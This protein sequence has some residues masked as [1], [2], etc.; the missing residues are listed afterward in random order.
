MTQ[1]TPQSAP[2]DTLPQTDHSVPLNLKPLIIAYMS[3][4]MAM[5]A[6]V[7]LIGPISRSLHLA[8][9]QA[10]A[11]VTVGGVLWM[12]LSRPWGALS[13]KRGR[14][15]VLL[16]GVG[17]FML[18]YWAMCAVLILSLH[19]Q[20]A[21]WV[22]FIGLLITRGAIGGFFAAIPTTSQA[23]IAD[24]IAPARRANVM[25]SLGAANGIGLVA[26][27]AMAAMLA[28]YG[29]DLPLYLTALLPLLALLILWRRLPRTT[30]VNDIKP[31]SLRLG[32]ARLRQAML[33]AFA[34]M[35]SVAVGQIA[36]G[37]FAI[38]RLGLE[39]ESAAQAAGFAL[40]L[41]G[42][43]LITS[44]LIVRKLSWTPHRL[45]R[46][47]GLI[48][49][50]GFAAVA[51]VN[52]QWM[53]MLCYFFAAAG[54]GWIFP[55][56]SALAANAV[57]PHEQGAAAGSIGA[58]QGLGIVLG[59]LAGSLLYEVSPGVPYVLVGILLVLVALFAATG[60]TKNKA[61]A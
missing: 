17:G 43:G 53:L 5:M 50:A 13:D 37:F 52:S 28:K 41:V 40:T 18:A 30:V 11:V 58:A 39:P 42:V 56:F 35:F 16:I 36:V 24:H 3:C 48:S 23:L 7:S 8:P 26:G 49:A 19:L 31:A 12:L 22:V 47:G 27:P 54:M 34:A 59:P 60:P 15:P 1:D 57:E 61:T 21:P 45:I 2:A 10:G 44:Q 9:W 38:D 29:L 4:T 33:V 51:L 20:A 46:V 55:A 14:R 6:F 25:A 32:D